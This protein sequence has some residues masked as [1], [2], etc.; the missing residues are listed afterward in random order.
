M[1]VVVEVD[2]VPVRVDRAVD[3]LDL[4]G[5]DLRDGAVELDLRLALERRRDVALVGVDEVEPLPELAVAALE[6]EVRLLVVR[7]DLEDLLEA[8]RREV[9]LEELLLLDRRELHE[10]VDA[11]ALGR[12][13]VELLLEDV[14][15]VGPLLER[16][17]RRARG[18]AAPARFAASTSSDLAVDL[19]RAR[20][21][22]S[23][24]VS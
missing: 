18:R 7:V 17:R 6:R 4:V 16:P 9:G 15:E 22:R 24:L 13:D 21:D 3:V 2:D 8:L 14:D 1:F 20:R 5:V 10:D 23:R 12:H 11:L 19:R